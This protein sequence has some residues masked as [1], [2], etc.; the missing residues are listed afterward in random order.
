MQQSRVAMFIELGNAFAD[1]IDKLVHLNMQTTRSLLCATHDFSQQAMS[2]KEPSEWMT[3][4]DTFAAPAARQVQDYNRQWLDIAAATQ[5][6]YARCAQAQLEE[7]GERTRTWL[8]YFAQSAPQGSGPIVAALDSAITA[9]NGLYGSLQQTGQ[10]A[11][12][13]ARTNVDMATT[14]A[15]K[16][17]RRT[18][19]LTD[20]ATKR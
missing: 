20:Q 2:T 15:A 10:Q 6:I 3:L 4:Q 19:E 11:L 1:G 9:V 17:A 7:Y 13:A 16:S 18:A 14:A 12:E 5:G 8:Q